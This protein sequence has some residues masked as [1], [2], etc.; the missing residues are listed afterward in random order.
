[1]K[2]S[3][4]KTLL[5]CIIDVPANFRRGD[6]LAFHARDTQ[7]IAERTTARGLR[8]GVLWDGYPACLSISFTA[9][10]ANVI[11]AVDG[12]TRIEDAE[13][14][15]QMVYHMLGLDQPVEHFE[16]QYE[17][18]PHLGPLLAG[19]PGLRVP[20]SASPF[21]ALSWAIIGQQVS[22]SAAISIR[23]KFIQA[24]GVRH[25]NGLWCFPD[26]VRVIEMEAAALQQAGFSG[27]KTR[28]L[29]EL[30]RSIATKALPLDEWLRTLP[31]EEMQQHLLGVRGIGP[32]TVSYAML[33]G[34]GWLDGSL[35]GDVAV[36]RNM[37]RLLGLEEKVT[38]KQAQQWLAEFSPW[39]ALVAA[40]LWAMQS[41][42]GY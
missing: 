28:A 39:R 38:E 31:V 33:R 32:W 36:R 7:M 19:Q 34:F 10:R 29:L 42:D 23:R 24:A 26:A 3:A 16:A 41:A 37:G 15:H 12:P 21:E 18:H 17:N 40:H 4:E 27:S 8:K 25:S 2:P 1:M 14:L 13:R 22:V 30:S 5:R 6:F 35:H 9:M 11:L 20:Q